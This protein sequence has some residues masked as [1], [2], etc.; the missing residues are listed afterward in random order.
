MTEERI[1]LNKENQALLDQ[2]SFM[3]TS[4]DMFAMTK[5]LNKLFL[6]PWLLL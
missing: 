6:V 2:V 1:T 3:V 5:Q 4:Q